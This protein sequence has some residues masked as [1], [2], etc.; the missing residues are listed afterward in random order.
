MRTQ[1]KIA[2]ALASFVLFSVA[3]G[4]AWTTKRLTY[5]SEYSGFPA[6]AVDAA[7]IY[8]VYED[9]T[10]GDGEIYFKK[11]TDG[12]TTWQAAKR[13]TYSAGDSWNPVIGLDG[14]NVYLAWDDT[15]PGNKEIYFKRSTDGGATWEAA[16]RLTYNSYES[17]HPVLA[18]QGANLYLAWDNGTNATEYGYEIYLRKSTDGGATWGVAQR[19]T[20]NNFYSGFPALAVDA[21]NLYAV[22][23]DYSPGNG[24]VYLKKSTDDGTTWQTAKRL[25]YTA[26]DSWGP[27]LAINGAEFYLTWFDNTPGNFDI[28]F[29]QSADGGSTW[30]ATKKITYNAGDSLNPSLGFSGANIYLAWYDNTPGNQE[31]YFR[32]SA[33]GGSTWQSLQRITYTSGTSENPQI[34]CNSTNIYIVYADETPGNSEIYLKYQPL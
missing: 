34:A 23:E 25:T 24:E 33:D 20:S 10:T 31:I 14:A 19:L 28:Y 11:S 8:V 26:G 4:A 3:L 18:I 21:D 30:Q 1:I 29:R 5:N 12:G 6:I 17:Q 15:A 32:Q 22:Y 13:L 27:I 9:Y 16:K 7:N 2:L